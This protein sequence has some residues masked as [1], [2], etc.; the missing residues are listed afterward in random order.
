[1]EQLGLVGDLDFFDSSLAPIATNVI[2]HGNGDL[3]VQLP[4]TVPGDDYYVRV[5]ADRPGEAYDTGNYHLNL[6]FDTSAAEIATATYAEG[7]LSRFNR[8]D[9]HTMFVAETQLFNLGIESTFHPQFEDQA[10]WMTIYAKGGEIVHQALTRPGEFRSANS[11]ILQPGTYSI[12]VT[13]GFAP[14]SRPNRRPAQLKYRI[15][16]TNIGDPI[17]PELIRSGRTPFPK[18]NPATNEYCYP[19]DRLTEAPFLVVEGNESS[20]P[21]NGTSPPDHQDANNWFWFQNWNQPG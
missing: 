7:Q 12:R 1:M 20:L 19:G 15:R 13:L 5:A 11:V 21:D 14:G 10:V 8:Q 6:R 3:V 9:I 17:G 4:D 2:Q 16:G 18:C